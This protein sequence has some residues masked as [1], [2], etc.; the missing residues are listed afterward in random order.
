MCRRDEFFTYQ[1]HCSRDTL[2]HLIHALRCSVDVTSPSSLRPYGHCA[3]ATPRFACGAGWR[4]R[5]SL[6]EGVPNDLQKDI[7]PKRFEQKPHV[8]RVD[9][10]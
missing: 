5:P 3:M 8:T 7:D 6:T 10:G 2:R 9:F 1:L 4:H